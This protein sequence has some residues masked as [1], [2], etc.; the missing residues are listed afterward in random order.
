MAKPRVVIAGAGFAGVKTAK[1]LRGKADITLIAPTDR[2]VYLPLIHELVSEN[3]TPR[4]VSKR[5]T[6][7]FQTATLVQGKVDAIEGKEA[8]LESG[9]RIPFDYFVSA[10]GAEPNDFGIPGVR[11]HTFSFYSISDALLANGNLKAAAA[12]VY[13]RPVKVVVIG[14]SFTGVEVAGEVKEL[15]EKLDV[16][17]DIELLDAGTQ[18]FPH[19]ATEFQEG[20]SAALDE[21]GLKVRMGATITGVEKGQV[22]LGDEVVKADVILWCAGARPRHIEGVNPHTDLTLRDPD[23]DDVFIAGDAALFDRELGIPKLAQTAEGQAP[24]VAHN[25]LH[26]D[27]MKSYELDLKGVIVSIGQKRAVAQIGDTVMAGKI[28]WHLKKR[29]YKTKILLY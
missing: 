16:S 25:I 22:L 23:R 28:P 13:G 8:V 24:I 1:A 3:E 2:F 10:V 18:I 4:G 15:M 27:R 21:L 19:Q 14:A 29:L 12:R 7:I 26:P 20:V 5:L 17:H 9:E 11:D 6:D